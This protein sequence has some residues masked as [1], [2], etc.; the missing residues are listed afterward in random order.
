L[1][2]NARWLNEGKV[3]ARKDGRAPVRVVLTAE[4]LTREAA[5]LNESGITQ[6]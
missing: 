2:D 3:V 4:K 5:E 6:G 1:N